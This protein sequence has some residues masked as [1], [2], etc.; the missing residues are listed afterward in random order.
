MTPELA[1][2]TF[3]GL[4]AAEIDFVS[5]LPES[6]LPDILPLI[7]A[8]PEMTMV[9][10]AHEGTAVSLAC[11]AALSGRRPAVYMEG[12]GFVAAMYNIESTAMQFGLPLLLLIAYVGSPGDKANST[13]F[14]LWGR[15]LVAQIEALGLQYRV[16]EDGERLATRIEDMARAAGSAKQPACLLFTGEFTTF[17]GEWK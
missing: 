13:T 17:T 9:R 1:E 12:T 14:S 7:D 11:G 10:A 5:F 6:R 4:K 2:K 3:A 8:D 16:L 15:R